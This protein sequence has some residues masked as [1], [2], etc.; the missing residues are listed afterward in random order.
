[1]C[2][3]H[4]FGSILSLLWT[5]GLMSFLYITNAQAGQA[6]LAWDANTEPT[7]GAINSTTG[8]PAVTTLPT[9]MLASRLAT[10]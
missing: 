6:T 5:L 7:L 1:M 9:S 10:P 4:P 3:K 8:K 2:L